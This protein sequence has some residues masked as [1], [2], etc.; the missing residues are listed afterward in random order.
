MAQSTFTTG[1]GDADM[2]V[3]TG[4]LSK[5]PYFNYQQPF[6][7]DAAD[8]YWNETGTPNRFYGYVSLASADIVN[9]Q[10]GSSSG[11]ELAG[12]PMA[13]SSSSTPMEWVDTK[14]VIVEWNAYVKAA[15]HSSFMG[16]NHYN[17]PTLPAKGTATDPCAGFVIDGSGDWFVKASNTGGTL[18]TENAIGTNPSTNAWHTFRIV[19]DQANTQTVF[20]I[21]G[22][23]VGTITTNRPNGA[24]TIGMIFG[25]GT[26][27]ISAVTAPNI[28]VEL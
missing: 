26:S 10:N 24:D 19:Q 17:D 22:V 27:L 14:I 21:D 4:G 11:N 6:L 18:T 3:G 5:K 1:G 12:F 16:L 8:E 13:S 2:L 25:G 9:T 15:G 28:S 7:D 23:L 20:Y